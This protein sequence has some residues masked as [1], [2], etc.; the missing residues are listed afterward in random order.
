MFMELWHTITDIARHAP[1]PHNT[2]PWKMRMIR[3]DHA[4]LLLD[5]ERMLPDE[6]TTGSFIVCAMGIF[7]ESL[8]IVS[9]NL[10]YRLRSESIELDDRASLIPFARLWLEPDATAV[11]AFSND[12][13]LA[14]RT[15]RLTPGPPPVETKTLSELSAIAGSWGQSF[16]HTDDHACIRDVLERNIDAVFHDL[17]DP[18]YHDE[19]VRWFRYGI[20]H[21]RRTNDGLASRCMNMSAFE[22]YFSAKFPM[23]M[24]V[25]VARRL[26]RAL[27]H[28]RLGSAQQ[29]GFLAGPFWDRHAAER[30]GGCL[31][32]L[33]LALTRR[34]AYLHP[35]GNLVTN[36][37]SHEWLTHRVGTKDIWLVFR[38]GRTAVPP[39][40]PR[41]ATE[42]LLLA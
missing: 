31:L 40:S 37:E 27:Y 15:S 20:A 16:R 4:E 5:R 11:S 38:F 18:R 39:K 32:H 41:L 23:L 2:Q 29:V 19:I 25:P 13:L 22:L 8:R 9:G 21:E 7:I 17:N 30:A 3:D 12:L 10:G 1:S 26:M 35:F 6:D 42:E 14:R 28:L 24:R 36:V 34:G 33:W